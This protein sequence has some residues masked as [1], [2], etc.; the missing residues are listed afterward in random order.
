[1]MKQTLIIAICL[2]IFQA[3]SS[4]KKDADLPKLP[5]PV[6]EPEVITS[7]TITFTDSANSNNTVIARFIDNDGDGGNQPTAFDTIK[8]KPNTSYYAKVAIFNGIVGEE[9]TE[10]IEEEAT[11]HLFIYKPTD[12]ALNVVITDKD[13]NNLPIGLQSTWRT[14]GNSSGSVQ[15][16]LKHQLGIKDGTESPGETDIDLNF[17]TEI[18]N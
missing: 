8:L 17:K 5:S 15:V 16:I 3:I 1:M 7:F 9:I 13:N 12:V 18:L 10:E 2:G 14:G 11:D 4:C 6:N